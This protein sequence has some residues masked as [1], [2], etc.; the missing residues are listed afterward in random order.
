MELPNVWTIVCIKS[1]S[2]GAVEYIFIAK[3][4]T[5]WTL[6]YYS[7]IYLLNYPMNN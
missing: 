5:G 7:T 2:S 1:F 4:A 3:L 6:N